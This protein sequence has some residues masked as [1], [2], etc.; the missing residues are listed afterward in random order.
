MIFF[1]GG[2]LVPMAW[3]VN[4]GGK[5][6]LVAWNFIMNVK[7]ENMKKSRGGRFK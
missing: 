6:V 7:G 3:K 2:R 5:S 4:E 1:E